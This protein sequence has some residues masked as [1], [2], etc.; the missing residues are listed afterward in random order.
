MTIKCSINLEYTL[1]HDR[2]FAIDWFLFRF[3][4]LLCRFS[5]SLLSP[6]YWC[7]FSSPFVH[8]FFFRLFF[9][10]H[11][12]IS[13]LYTRYRTLWRRWHR[14]HSRQR[15]CRRWRCSIRQ[16]LFYHL[17]QFCLALCRYY[18]RIRIALCWICVCVCEFFGSSVRSLLLCCLFDDEF[19]E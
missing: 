13:F 9:C 1:K 8:S 3:Y 4:F 12:V 11:F 6:S 14:H 10:P 5:R 19:Y 7:E 2:K 17:T 18:H 16:H 15:G